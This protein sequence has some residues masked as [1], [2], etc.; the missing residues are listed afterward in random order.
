MVVGCLRKAPAD[1]QPT[2]SAT[3]ASESAASESKLPPSV[4]PAAIDIP[5][6]PERPDQASPRRVEQPWMS[7]VEWRRRYEKQL[8]DPR[9]KQAKLV[10]L[11][12]SIVEAWCESR[13]F[14]AELGDHQPLNLGLGG[15]QTQHLAWRIDHGILD[16][17]TPRAVILLIGV[18]NLGNGFSPE[19][20][21][22]GV[23]AV[24]DRIMQKLPGTPVLLLAVLPAGETSSDGLRAKVA[25]MNPQLSALEV[26]GM[27][28][29]AD[30]GGVFL[31][32]DGRISRAQMADFLHPTAAGYERLSAAVRPLVDELVRRSP[33]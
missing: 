29:V 6:G 22:L 30:V 20:T 26:P 31:E 24:L 11:G 13:A 21:L 7:L 23:R 8:S 9:R 12:D 18:N 33:K 3:E 10:V 14:R 2:S 4:E 17:L 15:D 19:E 27:V 28:R 5:S 1:V 25:A 16:G 32:G